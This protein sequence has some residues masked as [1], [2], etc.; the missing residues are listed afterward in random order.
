MTDRRRIL[1]ATGSA[2]QDELVGA[3]LPGGA[4]HVCLDLA[5]LLSA[6]G[7]GLAGVAVVGP[8]LPLL[9]R[10]A[11]L[12]LARSGVAVIG[13][14]PADDP[15]GAAR[16][17]RLGVDPACV[18][19]VGAR[20]VGLASDLAAAVAAARAVTGR[21]VARPVP[22]RRPASPGVR[23]V[24]ASGWREVGP[25]D[26]DVWG[27]IGAARGVD[28]PGGVPAEDA[29]PASPADRVGSWAA[30]PADPVDPL[31]HPGAPGTS[32]VLAVWGPTGA[33]GR[34][35]IALTIAG[36]AA[37]RGHRVLLADLDPYGGSVARH[38][39]VPDE[40]PG[41]VAALRAA[42]EGLLDPEVLGRHVESVG[43]IAVLTGVPS[44]DRWPELRAAG[45][46]GLLDVARQRFDVVVLDTGFALEDDEELS[47]DTLAPRRNAATLSA[48]AEA[49][50]VV[51]VGGV[52]PVALP[53]LV[54][55]LSDLDR[56][57][58]AAAVT[59]V[60]NRVR[61]GVLGPAGQ[62]GVV[63][64]LRRLAGVVDPVLV[65][66]DP[67]RIDTALL[68]GRTLAQTAPRSSVARAVE[69][70]VP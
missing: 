11:L 52:G 64:D 18:V 33:P 13:A 49:D 3:A 44:A 59:V 48:L 12:R 37:R 67:L 31:D 16:L 55:G 7:V 61:A 8:A 27:D 41:V 56:L 9:D 24:H 57:G 50:R 47:Y 26:L 5:D 53:R 46:P 65:P 21:G 63:G 66:D 20:D 2:S 14:H 40:S 29:G 45:V 62:D 43:G 54:T 19:P 58:L 28:E 60:V 70:L 10:S 38:L 35:T 1:V 39:R 15:V 32:T 36:L 30:D 17:Q 42:D 22:T 23:P 6:A 51:A 34:T 69:P 25:D 68:H 4:A